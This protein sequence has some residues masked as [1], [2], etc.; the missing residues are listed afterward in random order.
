KTAF[1][2]FPLILLIAVFS[3][4]S[5]NYIFSK[6][7]NSAPIENVSFQRLTFS[8][9]ISFPVISPDGKSFAFVREGSIFVQDVETGSNFKLNVS[10]QK[11]FGNLQFSRN[12]EMIVFRNEDRNDAGGDIFE[13]SRF[14][15]EARRI[16]EN[17]WS[18]GSFAP[19]GK[20]LAF[21]RFLPEQA[22]WSLFVK[23]LES[24]EERKL[25]SR[26]S[27]NTIYRSGFPSWSADGKTILTVEQVQNQTNSSKLL[28]V[29]AESGEAKT[30]ETPRLVQIEQTVWQ[31]NEK[32]ILLVGRE[33]NRFFQLWKLNSE[34][35]DLQR[36]TNDLTIYRNLT[37]SADGKFLLA[38]QQ[39][40]N[41]HIWT[42]S[43]DDLEN[44]KQITFGNL[45]RDGNAGITWTADG[46][47]VYASRITGNVDLWSVNPQ[48]G[49][50]RQLTENAGTNN[51]NPVGSADGKYIY[52]E[53]NRSTTRHIWRIDTNGENPKQMTFSEKETEYSPVVSAD[54]EWLYF[55][56]KSAKSNLICRK[57]LVNEQTEAF[58]HIENVAP[59]AILSISPDGNFL[60]FHGI[61]EKPKEN[62]E[63][64]QLSVNV[65]STQKENPSVKYFGIASTV[66]KIFWSS[67]SKAL[68]YLEN[69]PNGDAKIWQQNLEGETAPKILLNLPKNYLYRLALSL[70][71][72][73]L[74]IA[75]GKNESDAI[76]LKNF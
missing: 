49:T 42:A 57:N 6:Q 71:G 34:T 62:A 45:N 33:K 70:D 32:D 58:S 20:Q 40:I 15:G 72:K 24:A 64:K 44:L 1:L 69:L 21:I 4:F 67:D 19:D 22:E 3:A 41:S 48:D 50:R 26:T 46:N 65:I 52:F 36:V 76:L 25:L 10:N 63:N 60:A 54:G 2:I 73:N 55:I 43:V 61:K 56:Q 68:N 39:T 37:I 13:V 53:S 27:P 28:L 11:V 66:S 7:T 47:I 14:G 38:R 75:K 74:A 29:N 59:D 51:E 30:L 35:N 23:N 17:A 12:G 8:G 9:D 31:P 5:I 16:S 18:G